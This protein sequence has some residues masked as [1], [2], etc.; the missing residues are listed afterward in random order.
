MNRRKFLWGATITA[1]GA[2]TIGVV[3]LGHIQAASPIKYYPK[4][5]PARYCQ[6]VVN[7]IPHVKHVLVDTTT[8]DVTWTFKNNSTATFLKHNPNGQMNGFRPNGFEPGHHNQLSKLSRHARTWCE[9]FDQPFPPAGLIETRK[10]GLGDREMT[11]TEE[12]TK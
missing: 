7:N 3:G 8:G 1:A 5:Q 10:Q 4:H 11:D 6:A 12:G 2:V 9:I